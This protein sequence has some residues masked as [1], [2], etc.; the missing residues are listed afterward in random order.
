[1]SDTRT[2]LGELGEFG[3]IE[4]LTKNF[5]PKRED[6]IKSIGDDAAVIDRGDHFELISTDL[7]VEGIHFDMSYTPLKHLGYKSIVVNLSDIYAMNGTPTH[8]TVAIAA[9]SRF[10][11]E[12]LEELYKGIQLACDTYGVDLVGG[13]TSSSVTGLLISPTVVGRVDKDKVVYR[14]GAKENDL[15]CVSGNLGAAYI[16][17]QILERE[18]QIWKENPDVQP[19]LSGHDYVIERMLKPE[20]RPDIVKALAERS[21]VPTSM[22]DVSDGLGSEVLH[23]CKQSKC[24]ARLFEEKIP[25]DPLVASQAQE[26]Q[27]E[28]SVCAMNGGEDYELLFTLSQADYEKAK[29]IEDLHFIGHMTDLNSGAAIVYPQGELIEIK[30]QGWKAF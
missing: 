19:D 24:G 18:K 10:P 7:L 5:N 29:D 26:F 16:G 3:L 30:S 4:H 1:M 15:L 11:V 21:I 20:P 23:I 22:I 17:L 27:L 12:A 9:S 13:D 25:V 8:V 6:T 14:S 2:E 28:P